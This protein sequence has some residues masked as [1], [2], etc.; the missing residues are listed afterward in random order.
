MQPRRRTASA[1]PRPPGK[2]QERGWLCK[3]EGG[4]PPHHPE[5]PEHGRCPVI[6]GEE[7]GKGAPGGDRPAPNSPLRL[8]LWLRQ[9]QVVTPPG[10]SDRG[11]PTSL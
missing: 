6:S 7:G 3:E 9:P 1:A 2:E 10:C 8:R 5:H 4:L 11:S